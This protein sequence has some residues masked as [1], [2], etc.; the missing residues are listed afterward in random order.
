MTFTESG[1]TILQFFVMKLQAFLV[2]WYVLLSLIPPYLMVI[3]NLPN[4]SMP[5]CKGLILQGYIRGK[6]SVV[7]D[8]LLLEQH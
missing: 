1:I 3:Y 5:L 8:S 2:A 7:S 4:I 6:V